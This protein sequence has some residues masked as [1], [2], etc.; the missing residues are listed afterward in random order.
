MIIFNVIYVIT[1]L[2]F[3]TSF[4]LNGD[5]VLREN[6]QYA[7]TKKDQDMIILFAK[8]VAFIPVVNTIILIFAFIYAFRH[9]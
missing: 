9:L 4:Y 3:M 6:I 5:D 8:I 1:V 7:K 2:T